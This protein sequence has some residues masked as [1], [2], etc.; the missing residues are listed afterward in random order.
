MKPACAS[1]PRTFRLSSSVEGGR[2]EKPGGTAGS[3]PLITD[4]PFN[5]E[6]PPNR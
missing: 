3:V 2:P 1:V 6:T 5:D 4:P